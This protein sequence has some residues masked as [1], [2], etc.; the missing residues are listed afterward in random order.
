MGRSKVLPPLYLL[1][2]FFQLLFKITSEQ[3]TYILLF[4]CLHFIFSSGVIDPTR[5]V[6]FDLFWGQGNIEIIVST[7]YSIWRSVVTQYIFGEKVN[8]CMNE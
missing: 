6:N 1:T 3:K 8:V 5:A 7:Y 4:T 2:C